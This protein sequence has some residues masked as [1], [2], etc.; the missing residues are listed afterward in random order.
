MP[1]LQKLEK[2]PSNGPISTEMFTY[3]FPRWLCLAVLLLS[4]LSLVAR[5]ERLCL[6]YRQSDT[7][8]TEALPIGNGRLGAMIFG[9]AAQERLQLNEDTLYAGGPYG[10]AHAD[11]LAALPEVRRF[12]LAGD[13]A[14]AQALA[15]G[16]EVDIA[17]KE[18]R[19]AVATVRNVT[20]DSARC[21]IRYGDKTAEFKLKA[22]ASASFDSGLNR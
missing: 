8:W 22:G 3:R 9:A 13:Y 7:Q 12:I 4:A 21:R 15:G 5:G 20:G 19:L 14:A 18:G 17:W 2:R 11:A 1:T 10:N 6:W 16:F